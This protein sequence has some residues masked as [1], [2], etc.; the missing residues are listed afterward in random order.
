[1]GYLG[2]RPRIL[3]THQLQYLHDADL[4]IALSDVRNV[5]QLNIA[6]YS[7]GFIIDFG[8]WLAHSGL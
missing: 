7:C 6:L 5:V 8:C 2:D 3:V 1:M 4:I